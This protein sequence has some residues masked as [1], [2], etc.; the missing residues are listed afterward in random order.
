MLYFYILGH[1]YIEP[2]EIS[3]ELEVLENTGAFIV[4]NE[5]SEELNLLKDLLGSPQGDAD[6]ATKVMA[7]RIRRSKMKIDCH[8]LPKHFTRAQRSALAAKHCPNLREKEYTMH[9][10]K[11]AKILSGKSNKKSN[12]DQQKR[13]FIEAVN[14]MAK[15]A[16]IVPSLKLG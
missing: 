15:H 7:T 1:I 13:E 12:L 9:A 16:G 3:K 8:N 2:S 4:N 6:T 14:E 11:V 5:K 10:N